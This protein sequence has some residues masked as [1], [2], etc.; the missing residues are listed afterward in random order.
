MA[1][2]RK[3]ILGRQ[4]YRE[5]E[6]GIKT[7]TANPTIIVESFS[8]V[9]GAATAV[10]GSSTVG[11]VG[12]VPTQGTG[13]AAA[14]DS[15]VSASGNLSFQGSGGATADD[16]TV[17]S[18]A[19][20]IYTG[21]GSADSDDS[22]VA[23]VG[24]LISS[25]GTGGAIASDSIVLGSGI[26]SE[27]T[28]GTAKAISDSSYV[29]SSGNVFP[30]VTGSI[31][32]IADNSTISSNG[33][34]ADITIGTAS[35]V[36]DDSIVSSNGVILPL[37]TGAASAI[38]DSSAISSSGSV[39]PLTIGTGSAVADK[40]EANS[41]GSILELTT[42]FGTVKPDSAVVSGAGAQLYIGTGV[43]IAKNSN[44]SALATVSRI[45][46]GGAVA[47]SD[48]QVCSLGFVFT[49]GISSV[50]SVGFLSS[51]TSDEVADVTKSLTQSESGRLIRVSSEGFD[52]TDRTDLIL[53]F[54]KP[55]G[56]QVLKKQSTGDVTLG[57]VDVVDA[58]LGELAANTYVEYFLEA[59]L[60]SE[61]GEPWSVCLTYE[62]STTVPTT[63]FE[64]NKDIFEV[65]KD[66]GE[67]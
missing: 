43:V 2:G 28:I 35:I 60:L 3:F 61:W 63:K 41:S 49:S 45:G 5:Q 23:S 50:S 9:P 30:F 31:G 62:D 51:L 12:V 29:Q 17:A 54:I 34:V 32:A 26:E 55:S 20:Q 40:S 25:I 42:G 44:V 8:S 36:A 19:V 57:T 47:Q 65:L 13:G 33:I 27:N 7:T 39:L 56:E 46:S 18:T 16:S 59:D 38:A 10:A 64:G 37:T 67:V 14:N 4:I 21:T 11:A 53:T 15:A 48:T 1:N 58:D 66:C 22:T 52:M 6:D 24:E